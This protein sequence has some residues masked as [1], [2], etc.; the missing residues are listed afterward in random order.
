MNKKLIFRILGAI[1]S[2]LII[3]SLFIPFVSVSGYTQCLWDAY[4]NSGTIYLPIMIIV[5]GAIGLLVFSLNI[6][7]EIAYSTTGALLFYLISET[8]SFI[9]QDMMKSLSVGYY[10]LVIGTILTGVMAFL[11][12]LKTKEKV[13]TNISQPENPVSIITQIDTLYSN[14]NENMPIQPQPVQPISNIVQPIPEVAMQSQP[15]QP[16]PEVAMQPQP[17]QPVPEVAMQP[18]LINNAGNV[19]A[20]PVVA[21]FSSLPISEPINSGVEN[22]PNN[23]EQE[24]LGQSLNPVINEFNISPNMVLPQEPV[25]QEPK[26]EPSTNNNLDIFNKNIVKM[27]FFN[28]PL[29]F[30]KNII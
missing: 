18:Q 8:I 24:L 15:V 29:F 30:L 13:V 2:A 11:N 10:C 28:N 4:S 14:Q 21:E 9:D 7:I 27:F 25:K 12:N 19:N 26:V 17:V 5:F 1:S 6:K 22:I 3:V 16:I 20:N 23:N